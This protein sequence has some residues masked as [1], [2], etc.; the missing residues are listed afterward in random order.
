MSLAWCTINYGHAVVKSCFLSSF[1]Y[2][3]GATPLEQAGSP[4]RQPLALELSQEAPRQGTLD[5]LLQPRRGGT[6]GAAGA[7]TPAAAPSA[8]AAAGKLP[9]TSAGVGGL[10]CDRHA[11]CGEDDIVVAKPK[12]VQ[13]RS[14]MAALKEHR[15]VPHCML[16]TG[17]WPL[18]GGARR[19]ACA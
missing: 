14:W 8:A 13:L 2:P 3:A 10:W 19:A 18:C 6:R 17:R 11:P 7:A 5:E 16:L 12:V 1:D 15:R 4:L 9:A